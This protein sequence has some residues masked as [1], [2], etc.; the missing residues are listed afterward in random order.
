VKSVSVTPPSATVA[1]GSTTQLTAT[2]NP[3]GSATTFVWAS[4]NPAVATVSSTGLVKGV[5]TGTASITATAGEKTGTSLIT[6]PAP[7]PPP[8]PPGS[9]ILVGA[10]D[11]ADCSS[12]AEA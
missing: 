8:P 3:T 1:I 4:S 2:A 9:E 12:G 10:G 7:P 6:V 5:A 11:I